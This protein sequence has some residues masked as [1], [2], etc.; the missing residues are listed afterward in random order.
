MQQR[1]SAA[2]WVELALSLLSAALTALT[3]A[4]PDWMEGIFEIDPDEGSGSSEWVIALAF[5][6]VT[7]L[8]SVLT[9][10]TWRRD[11]RS[12]GFSR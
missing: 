7:V 5:I 9:R 6:V 3:I 2:F 4:W 11:R 1:F 8:L 10:R 12:A